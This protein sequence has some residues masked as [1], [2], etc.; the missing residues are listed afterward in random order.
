[1]PL[2]YNHHMQILF[3]LVLFLQQFAYGLPELKI[4]L[5]QVIEILSEYSIIQENSVTYY[6]GYH[7]NT[8][9]NNKTITICS[10]RDIAEKRLTLC[11]EILHIM[12]HRIGIE[13]SGPWEPFI[14]WKAHQAFQE[15]YGQKGLDDSIQ[16]TPVQ[17]PQVP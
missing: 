11:H 1:M 7:G 5:P 6:T 3:G 8:D 16:E 12:Y 14:D 9:Y 13:T 10:R 4:N 17:T 2:L 15:I